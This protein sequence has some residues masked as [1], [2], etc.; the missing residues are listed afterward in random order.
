VVVSGFWGRVVR[1]SGRDC[2]EGGTPGGAYGRSV[3]VRNVLNGVT[4][5]ATHFHQ[6]FV[7]EGSLVRPGSIL[8]SPCNAALAGKPGTTH[9]HLGENRP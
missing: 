9:I 3:Y 4:R 8:G 7:R 1:I 2:L 5:Y 6:L